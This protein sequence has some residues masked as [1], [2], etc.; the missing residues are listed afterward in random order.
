M[1]EDRHICNTEKKRMSKYTIC[2]VITIYIITGK[3]YLIL[4]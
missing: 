4:D 1:R 2:I 3:I